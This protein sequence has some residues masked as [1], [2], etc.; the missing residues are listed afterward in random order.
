MESAISANDSSICQWKKHIRG[1]GME[2]GILQSSCQSRL[3]VY[4]LYSNQHHWAY[5]K[6]YGKDFLP[7]VFQE[8]R[9]LRFGHISLALSLDKVRYCTKSPRY[10]GFLCFY[11][12]PFTL[13]FWKKYRR[14][15]SAPKGILQR[16]KMKHCLSFFFF[17]YL[18]EPEKENPFSKFKVRLM[19][20][21]SKLYIKKVNS[22]C[23]SKYH[24]I[25]PSEGTSDF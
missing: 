23:L 20:S 8:I 14:K 16:Y 13:I 24:H 6:K 22:K 3:Q 12:Q 5:G 1:K 17:F 10:V 2:A 15:A 11:S 21:T 7:H 4:R 18:K 19:K 9:I 25:L